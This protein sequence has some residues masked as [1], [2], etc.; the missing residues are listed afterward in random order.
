MLIPV[1]KKDVTVRRQSSCYSNYATHVAFSSLNKTPPS[2]SEN[3]PHAWY[4]RPNCQFMR[5][6]IFLMSN[7]RLIQQRY[8]RR[9]TFDGF[10]MITLPGKFSSHG[11][12]TMICV[13]QEL[14][15]VWFAQCFDCALMNGNAS[16]SGVKEQP[17]L[18]VHSFVPFP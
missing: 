13:D 12:K 16:L 6:K 11:S 18:L 7:C 1:S 2:A 9:T 15:K 4:D 10:G 8:R 17:K 14:H 3:T 5:S